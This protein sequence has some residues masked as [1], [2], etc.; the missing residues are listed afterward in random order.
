MQNLITIADIKGGIKTTKIAPKIIPILNRF[1]SFP[2]MRESRQPLNKWMPAF[3]GVT[4]KIVF[5][6][7]KNLSGNGIKESFEQKIHLKTD[8]GENTNESHYS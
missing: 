2:R 1:S 5:D 7:K 8:G 6:L 3:A 4:N